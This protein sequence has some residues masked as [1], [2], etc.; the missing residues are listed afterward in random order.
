MGRMIGESRPGPVDDPMFKQGAY[1]V[2]VNGLRPSTKST[3][4]ATAG[5]TPTQPTEEPKEEK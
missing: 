4:S 1:L 3:G 2:G 5:E